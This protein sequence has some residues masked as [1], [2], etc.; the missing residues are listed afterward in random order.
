MPTVGIDRREGRVSPSV[1]SGRLP[2]RASEIALGARTMRSL[3]VGIGDTVDARLLD[4]GS[5]RLRVVGRVVLPGLGTTR[6][7][8]RRRS[9]KA[10]S[11]TQATLAELGPEFFRKTFLVDFRND[12]NAASGRATRLSASWRPTAPDGCEVTVQRPSDIV[13]YERVRTTP[14]VLAGLLALLALM[15]VTHA[16]VT[17]VRR[18][19]RDLALLKTLGFTRGQVSGTVA[20]QASTIGVIALVVGIPLGVVLGRWAW[21]ALANNLGTVSEPI[22]PIA[23][24]LVAVPVVLLLLNAVAYLPGR[25]AA[26]LRPATVLRSE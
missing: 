14:I 11:S 7:P 16:L 3:G 2:E 13:A 23:L 6:A 26:R 17:G 9:A 25:V 18:R 10:R 5:T 21:S 8:T 24:L 4:G 15:T 19:R 20:W 22:V 12:A 1:V